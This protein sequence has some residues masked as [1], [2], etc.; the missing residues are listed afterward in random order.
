MDDELKLAL[1]RQLVLSGDSAGN[2]KK[3]HQYLELY[4]QGSGKD[5]SSNKTKVAI[6]LT[7]AGEEALELYNTCSFINEGREEGLENGHDKVVKKFSQHCNP[8]RNTY[9]RFVLR[10]RLQGKYK[11]INNFIT[12]VKLKSISCRFCSNADSFICDQIV[13]GVYDM[14]LQERNTMPLR[15]FHLL[16][17]Q[18]C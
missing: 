7:C 5:L 13:V 14:K 4:L 12:D 18:I 2:W 15:R 9:E 10:S 16:T 17:N 3:I 1:P 11:P 6:L 8:K